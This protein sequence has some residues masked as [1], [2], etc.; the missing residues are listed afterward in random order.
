[1]LSRIDKNKFFLVQ[2]FYAVFVLTNV[3]EIYFPPKTISEIKTNDLYLE[4]KNRKQFS[5]ASK[6]IET[7]CVLA[8]KP[9]QIQIKEYKKEIRYLQ[10]Y[11]KKFSYYYGTFFSTIN[12]QRKD[13][14]IKELNTI[15]IR[16]LYVITG[17]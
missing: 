11:L 8:T 7:S 2:A 10:Q 5:F 9:T 13:L 12:T 17:N 1:M 4:F 16:M 3:N 15:A 14:K 6:L